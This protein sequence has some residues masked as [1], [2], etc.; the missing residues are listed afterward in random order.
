VPDFL[1]R[2]ESVSK[3]RGEEALFQCYGRHT[4]FIYT[5]NTIDLI[6]GLTCSNLRNL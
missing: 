2:Y 4:A 6:I 1:N 5:Y 3:I